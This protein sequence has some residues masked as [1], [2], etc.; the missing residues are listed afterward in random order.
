MISVV[1]PPF[2]MVFQSGQSKRHGGTNCKKV[3]G[4]PAKKKEIVKFYLKKEN[5]KVDDSV[6][7]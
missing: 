2:I 1:L 5:K 3:R 7:E 4:H 6:M